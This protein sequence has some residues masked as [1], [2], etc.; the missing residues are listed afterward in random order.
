MARPAYDPSEIEPRW[1]QR[2]ADD[3]LYQ[4]R[5]FDPDRQKWYALVMFPYTSGDLHVGH[6]F[7]YTGPD[8]HARY[9]RMKGYNV[10]FP[11]GFDA[12]GLPAENAAI[13][14][15]IQPS[16]YTSANIERMLT[17]LRTLGSTFEFGRQVSTSEP[18][19]YRWTQ[20]LFLQLYNKGLAYR[21]SA[22]VN[23]CPQDQTVLANEQ[24]VEGRCER[25]GTPVVKKELE[26]W[27]F[28]ITKYAEELLGFDGLDWP[29][30]VVTMQT[31]WIGR[32]EG[33]EMDFPVSLRGGATENLRI[34]TTRPDTLFGVTF[35]VLAPEHPLVQKV[36]T[37]Q[38]RAQV[39]AYA[40]SARNASDID[41]QSTEREK[42]GVFTGGYAT[43]PMNGERVPIWVADYVLMTYGTGAIMAVPAH[44]DRDFLFAK[45]F[46]LPVI[47]VI[48]PTGDPGGGLE[49]AY[50][51]EGSL[52]NSGRFNGLVAKSEG[53]QEIVDY[54]KA[55]GW[56]EPTVV[57]R[58]R[59]W[60]L[61]RQRYWGAPIPI[62]YCPDHGAVPVP[63]DQLPVLLPAQAEFR[64]TGDS[65][66][67][68]VRE[69]VEVSCPTCGKAARRETDTMDT[70]VDS[71]W[72]YLRYCSPRDDKAAFDPDAVRFWMPVDQYM[73]GVEHAILHLL[74][75]RFFVKAL[76]DC[77]LLQI[78]EPFRRLRN[79]GM[80]T[81][82]GGKMSKSKGNVR[83]PDA[84]VKSH[85]ADAVRLYMLFIAP[86]SDGGV[87]NEEGIDG[88]RR[89]L[90][91]VH[92]LATVAYPASGATDGDT[93]EERDLVRLTHQTVK[94]VTDDIENF[95]LNTY[96]SN[97]MKLRNAL[98]DASRTPA[99][100]SMA[101]RH[102]V[103]TLLVLLAPAAPH[104]A[105]ELWTLTGHSYSVHQQ[106]WPAYDEGLVRADEFELVVQVNGKVRDRM[107]LPMGIDEDRVRQTVL[108]RPKIVEILDGSSP[109]KIIYIQGK[110]LS[111]V[112]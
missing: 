56:G 90:T 76:R 65:P 98:Q 2:W 9:K 44:D 108:A 4:A 10:L 29:Q 107:M 55:Q 81:Y 1:Q 112:A 78:D 91:G 37:D 75:S 105:E 15:G 8:V 83:A 104:L 82:A 110:I 70:F 49:Q 46:G 28:R 39:E 64:P 88:T 101:Y 71:S 31:N 42:T 59:D 84:M 77:G 102:A 41:R 17:Q 30:K 93:A 97:L 66:L 3:A 80:I 45:K 20:W 13:K 54:V 79:Q 16:V 96:V 100:R 12:F 25:C 19:Y 69:F 21:A 57:Y 7:A 35:M 24:V 5:D 87:W 85:G 23:W 111:I 94:A 6:W 51:G 26:Q 38:Q 36:T 40:A 109:K 58:L 103:D 48:S 14:D 74:Y 67:A 106:H 68:S 72:Y 99:G 11:F 22:P 63:E 50:A 27:F 43:N 34:F 62:I 92:F 61:S 47:E 53:I 60:L 86:W 89:F 18:D 33:I 73:G 52:V 95:K 32:S